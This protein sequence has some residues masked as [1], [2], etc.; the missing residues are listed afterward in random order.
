MEESSKIQCDKCKKYYKTE[1][2]YKIHKCKALPIKEEDKE[3]YKQKQLKLMNELRD[4]ELKVIK[5]NEV[6]NDDDDDYD[7]GERVTKEEFMDILTDTVKREFYKILHIG[8]ERKLDKEELNNYLRYT[9][10]MLYLLA[11]V[12]FPSD[13]IHGEEA[14]SV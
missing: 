4:K 13:N 14:G 8:K 9:G 12:R 10:N 3:Q 11:Q 1:R 5:E 2:T 6:I 7:D